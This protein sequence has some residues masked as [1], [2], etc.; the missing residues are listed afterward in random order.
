MDILATPKH[1]KVVTIALAYGRI[2]K[3]KRKRAE[4]V[5]IHLRE[6]RSFIE[7]QEWEHGG[8]Y[9]DNDI[10]A[11]EFGNKAREDY[12]RM[13]EDI[14]NWPDREGCSVQLV[15]VV[16]EMPR[17]YRQ[18]EELLDLIKL[19]EPGQYGTPA[20]TKLRGIWTTDGE[21]Y[22]LSTPEGYHRAVGA[23]N[24]ARL[25]SMRASKRQLRK[26]RNQAA[27]G[28]YMGGQRRYGFEGPIKDD[29]GNIINRERINVAEI[30]EE[31]DRWLGWFNRLL[32][33]EPQMSIIRDNNRRG[34]PTAQAR[35]MVDGKWVPTEWTIGNFHRLMSQEAYVIFDDPNHPEDCPC[36]ENPVGGGTLV[37]E[38]SSTKHR[39]RWRGL[40]TKDQ[41][42]LL[43]AAF[44]AR[45]Q[46]H[47]HGLVRGRM[48]VL[49]G[50]AVCGG[51]YNGTLCHAPMYG[52]GRKL[53]DGKYQ[54]RYRCKG[55]NNHGERVAC[56]S[57]F[58]D[59]AALDEY[60]IDAVLDKFDTPE[61]ARALA[62]DDNQDEAEA[63]SLQMAAMKQ[64][65]ELLKRQYGRGEIDRLEDYKAMRAEAERV[66]EELQAK[67]RKITDRTAVNL[68]PADGNLRAVFDKADIAWQ[69]SVIQLVVQEVI[70]KP[71]SP[72]GVYKSRKFKPD[73]I[74]IVWKHL[75]VDQVLGELSVLVQSQLA[76]A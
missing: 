62:R 17:L 67:L 68:L 47:D 69:R 26:K 55:Q 13:V 46:H 4:N 66:F 32:A 39:A 75:T 27:Q 30:P 5:G 60:V 37:H 9:K 72:G 41:Y 52:N 61:V 35:K 73:D 44:E 34:I 65:L 59:A 36:L 56:G 58:R 18:L 50:I 45:S 24:N 6:C 20:P 7:D 54:R 71:S 21:G 15:I 51:T 40:I 14:K 12:W 28:K 74:E 76:A 63:I 10:T 49:S 16:T 8:D 43:L 22:D 70:V 64:R 25:E 38:S 48:Y 53:P 3:D 31:I 2:S 19:A 42:E 23:V 29:S 1:L 33:G 57:T 11:S